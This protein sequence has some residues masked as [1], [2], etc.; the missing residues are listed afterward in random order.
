MEQTGLALRQR[1]QP[2]HVRYGVICERTAKSDVSGQLRHFSISELLDQRLAS[3]SIPVEVSG[4][5][6]CY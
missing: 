1:N 2:L 4:Q 5:Q 6:K 3:R